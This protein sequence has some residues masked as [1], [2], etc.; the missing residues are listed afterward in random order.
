[1][2]GGRWDEA[3]IQIQTKNRNLRT[4]FHWFE[5][6]PNRMLRRSYYSQKGRGC[7]FQPPLPLDDKTV[8][9]QVLGAEAPCLPTCFSHKC[10]ILINLF[11]A[12]RL[13]LAEFL[14]CEGVKHSKSRHQVNDSN[15]KLWVQ[16]PIWV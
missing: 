15:L 11:L 3:C 6:T 12:Y 13:S 1:M 9:H 14:L 8:A 5:Y 7:I 4:T 16:V 2:L 10:P